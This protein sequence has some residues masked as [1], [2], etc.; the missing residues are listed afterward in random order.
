[1]PS[2]TVRRLVALFAAVLQLAVLGVSLADENRAT[3]AGGIHM[4]SSGGDRCTPP[5]ADDCAIC[6]LLPTGGFSPAASR[7]PAATGSQAVP[8]EYRWAS[9]EGGARGQ[10]PTRAPPAA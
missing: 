7:F 9:H 3:S 2:P 8:R 5:H 6:R 1:M 4:E 10:P